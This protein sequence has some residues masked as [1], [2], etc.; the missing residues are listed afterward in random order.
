MSEKHLIELPCGELK[1]K[2]IRRLVKSLSK[3]ISINRHADAERAVELAV[4][5][6][7]VGERGSSIKLLRSFAFD[8]Y[9]SETSGAW[10]MKQQAMSFLAYML[11][12]ENEQDRAKEIII[13]LVNSNPNFDITDIDWIFNNAADDID[14]YGPL[15]CWTPNLDLTKKEL[16]Q[17]FYSLAAGLMFPFL[18][19]TLFRDDQE[20]LRKAA[21]GIIERELECLKKELMND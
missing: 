16:T 12:L 14:F 6:Y 4:Y 18:L 19:A 21:K 11:I 20:E 10:E 3:G 13:E 8:M 1:S 7:A 9:Y 2:T 17:G 15:D 5:L